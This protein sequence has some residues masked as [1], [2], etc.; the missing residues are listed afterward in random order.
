MMRAAG[1]W[2]RRRSAASLRDVLKGDDSRAGLLFR[3]YDPELKNA[4]EP[5]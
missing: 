2:R 3:S 5:D 4:R 1:G